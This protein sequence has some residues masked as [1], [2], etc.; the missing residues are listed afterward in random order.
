MRMVLFLRSPEAGVGTLVDPL[1]FPESSYGRWAQAVH[2]CPVEVIAFVRVSSLRSQ[3]L[4]SPQAGHRS[5]TERSSIRS[6]SSAMHTSRRPPPNS[7][8]TRPHPQR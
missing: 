5:L 7:L 8:S 6:S 1:E 3:L 4:D 2:L